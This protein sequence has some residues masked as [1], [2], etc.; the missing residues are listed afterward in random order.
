[1][2]DNVSLERYAKPA[3]IANAV[4]FLASDQSSFVSGQVLRVDGGM[5]LFAG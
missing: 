1:M 3:E 4:A 2:I 5:S